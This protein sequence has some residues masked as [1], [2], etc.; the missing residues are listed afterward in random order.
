LRL[1]FL[2]IFGMIVTRFCFFVL[3]GEV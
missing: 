3:G 1:S 2:G